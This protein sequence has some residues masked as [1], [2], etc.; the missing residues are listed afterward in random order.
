[1]ETTL[2]VM[3]GIPGSGKSTFCKTKYPEI[4]HISR[5]E[6]RFNMLKDEEDYFSHEK[7]VTQKF[8][9]LINEEL[10]AG[11]SVFADQTSLNSRSRTWLLTHTLPDVRKVAVVMDIPFKICAERNRGR[12]GKER[13]PEAALRNMANSFTCPVPMEGFDQII[14]V[15]ENGEMV[16]VAE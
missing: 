14:L 15:R 10:A 7:E 4:K 16:V 6:I 12:H 8:W 1:M 5:D 3:C 11:H 9:D 13:V 2:F